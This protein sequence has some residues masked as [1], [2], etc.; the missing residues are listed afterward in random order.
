MKRRSNGDNDLAIA[1]LP[2]VERELGPPVDWSE[3]ADTL[4]LVK[5]DVAA[6]VRHVA[7]SRARLIAGSDRA[8]NALID[9]VLND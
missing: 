7:I 8:A 6:E 3:L 5:R 2:V 4:V 1:L 9:D